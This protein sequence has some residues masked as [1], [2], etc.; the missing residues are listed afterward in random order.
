LTVKRDTD[1]LWP[2]PSFSVSEKRKASVKMTAAHADAI[3][4]I[5]EC[6]DRSDDD[7]EFSRTDRR[8]RDGFPETELILF[9]TGFRVQRVK[10]HAAV[11]IDYGRENALFCAPGT[12]NDRSGV[13]F[14][15]VMQIARECS[16]REKLAAV[17]DV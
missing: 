9:E 11:S 8:R 6:N 10:A 12:L 7:V 13:D 3:E 2:Q 15:P 4:V 17:H 16:G 14:V 5:V 1:E